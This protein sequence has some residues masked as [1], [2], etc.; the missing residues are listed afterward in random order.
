MR[1]KKTI[2]VGAF[3][4]ALLLIFFT[5]L[6]KKTLASEKTVFIAETMANPEGTDTKENEYIVLKNRTESEQDLS[7]YKIC[8]IKNYCFTLNLKIES[9]GC[10]KI[11][12]SVFLF[13]LYNDEEKISLFDSVSNLID[14]VYFKSALSGK[15]WVCDGVNCDFNQPINN[16]EYT[17]IFELEEDNANSN[18][19]A[20]LSVETKSGVS[21]N[22]NSNSSLNLAKAEDD[23]LLEIET[24]K[25]FERAKKI[26][27]ETKESLP[28]NISAQAVIPKDVLTKSSF[29]LVKDGEW[30]RGQTYLSFCKIN[31]CDDLDVLLR[32]R[33]FLRIGNG[34]INW[35]GTVFSL[36]LGK[37]STVFR[38]P[39]L[40]DET[41]DW[42]TKEK[43]I[44]LT[45]KIG[46][47]VRAEGS[48]TMKK[49]NYFFV[50]SGGEELTFYVPTKVLTD[51]LAEEKE[52]IKK[53]FLSYQE[54]KDWPQLIYKEAFFEAE[55]VVESRKG[56]YRIVVASSEDLK[57]DFAT[58]KA[59][60]KITNNSNNNKS[61]SNTNKEA[62]SKNENQNVSVEKAV[63]AE[64]KDIDLKTFLAEKLS[65]RNL[66]RIFGQKVL[67]VL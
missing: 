5:T 41:I 22:S 47:K 54:E 34:Y 12:R 49:G 67:G 53:T 8:N 23:S 13:T 66:F 1:Q 64:E 38:E 45:K 30:I 20:Y 44:K 58:P 18:T 35:D 17:N 2:R 42:K 11:P 40:K 39:F 65:W 62:Q 25:D 28:V 21:K 56:S 52:L 55:G 15:P 3:I 36:S 19:N 50:A 27:L 48:V 14:E 43:P 9:L 24:K 51:W 46:R 4:C 57:I 60:K 26:I 59:K 10:A 61:I 63:F 33:S 37:E 32:Q 7:G 31:D 6:I 29:Y 16:C